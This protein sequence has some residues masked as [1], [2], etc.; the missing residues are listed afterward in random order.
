MRTAATAS[1]GGIFALMNTP[2]FFLC[3]GLCA[4]LGRAASRAQP[5]TPRPT[6]RNLVMEGGGIRGI[7]YGGSLLELE[8]QGLLRGIERVGGTSAGAATS[9]PPVPTSPPSACRCSATKPR[10]PCAWP[11]PCASA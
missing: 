7:A 10:P 2:R 5:T 11:M 8:Q 1:P 4:L 3:L 6:Y 9:A